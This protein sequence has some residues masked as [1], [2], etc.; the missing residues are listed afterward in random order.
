MQRVLATWS[1]WV[2]QRPFAVPVLSLILVVLFVRWLVVG[3][4]RLGEWAVLILQS[5]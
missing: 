5:A 4:W 3:L 2:D 1:Y